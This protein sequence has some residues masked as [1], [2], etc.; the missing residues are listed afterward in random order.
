MTGFFLETLSC[1]E[2]EIL[3]FALAGDTPTNSVKIART[4]INFFI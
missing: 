3:V 1:G 2:I 4:A